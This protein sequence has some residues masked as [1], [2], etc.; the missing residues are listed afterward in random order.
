MVFSM[1]Q[2]ASVRFDE[3]R[4]AAASAMPSAPASFSHNRKAA[5]KVRQPF[6]TEY[7]ERF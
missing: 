3:V 1:G 7:P 2:S 5:R 6:L 4:M